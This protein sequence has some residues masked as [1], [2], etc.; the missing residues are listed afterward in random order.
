M[1]SV[2]PTC[3][4][5][6][7]EKSLYCPTKIPNALASPNLRLNETNKMTTEMLKNYK[8]VIL[9]KVETVASFF[10]YIFSKEDIKS[11]MVHATTLITAITIGAPCLIAVYLL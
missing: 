7:T 2:A 5:H 6:S 1:L 10:V 4:Y 9:T 8:I 11:K 3:L